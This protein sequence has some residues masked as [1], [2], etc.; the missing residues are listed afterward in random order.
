MAV[1]LLWLCLVAAPGWTSTDDESKPPA[2]WQEVGPRDNSFKVWVP[3]GAGRKSERESTL[4]VRGTRMKIETVQFTKNGGPQFTAS[5]IATAGLAARRMR[6]QEVIESIRDAFVDSWKGRV[7]N[8]KQVAIGKLKGSDYVIVTGQGPIRMRVFASGNR[9]YLA[10]ISG[11]EDSVQGTTGDTFLESFRARAATPSAEIANGTSNTPSNPSRGKSTFNGNGLKI[12]PGDKFEYL[13]QAVAE[14]HLLEADCGGFKLHR[15]TYRDVPEAG[16]L[17]IGFQ[18]GF[19]KFVN[20][21]TIDAFRPIYLTKDGEVMGKWYGAAPARPTTYKAKSGYV[22]ASINL[23]AGLAI[24]GF[25][26]DFAKLD[27]D[28]LDMNEHY[29]SPWIGGQGGNRTTLGGQGHFY[30]GIYGHLNDKRAPSSLG[31]IVVGM[32]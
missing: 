19:G 4:L 3:A 16:G 18:V 26:M 25:S 13:K 6:P 1:G 21:T 7:E 32:K 10:M 23:N 14:N 28:H 11:S 15:D 24:D 29:A 30:A 2:G 5:T 22:V 20:N 17:L 9:I 8:E 12:F 27:K 31:L